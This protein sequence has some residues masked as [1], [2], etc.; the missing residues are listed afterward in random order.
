MSLTSGRHALIRVI[1]SINDIL[2]AENRAQYASTD[3]ASDKRSRRIYN[4]D[5]IITQ[6]FT[7]TKSEDSARS[8]EIMDVLLVSLSVH[9][10]G[11][12]AEK[13][14]EIIAN[15]FMI[16]HPVIELTGIAMSLC[17]SIAVHT[18]YSVIV[19]MY[20]F[21][22]YHAGCSLAST[23]ATCSWLVATAE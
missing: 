18:T 3:R 2:L 19:L 7:P 20:R 9:S 8:R 23:H 1:D 16:T 17:Q 10:C 12:I 11:Y 14:C 15:D 13:R 5:L 21:T 4:Q 22:A 6:S